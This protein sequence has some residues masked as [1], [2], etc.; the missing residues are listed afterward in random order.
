[1]LNAQSSKLAAVWDLDA[2]ASVSVACLFTSF[3]LSRQVMNHSHRTIAH[4]VD[5]RWC[6]R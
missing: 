4:S 6:A 5:Y 2:T 3:F 1:M